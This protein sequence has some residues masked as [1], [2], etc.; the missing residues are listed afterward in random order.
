MHYSETC[1]DCIALPTVMVC[2]FMSPK[3]AKFNLKKITIQVTLWQQIIIC[4][5]NPNAQSTLWPLRVHYRI[6]AMY[7]FLQKF[8]CVHTNCVHTN[9]DM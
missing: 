9:D 4:V 7:T 1:H 8:N 6:C 5:N 2:Q 3:V